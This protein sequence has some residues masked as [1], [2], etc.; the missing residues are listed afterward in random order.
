MHKHT[1]SHK[2]DC[3]KGGGDYRCGPQSTTDT[4]HQVKSK[5][6]WLSYLETSVSQS[7]V[8]LSGLVDKD[9]GFVKLSDHSLPPLTNA[10]RAPCCWH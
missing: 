1:H 8:Q 5:T 2:L 3:S 7:H 4:T 10:Q 9:K 6:N